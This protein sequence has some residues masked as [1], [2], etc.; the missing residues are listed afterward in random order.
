MLTINEPGH[1]HTFPFPFIQQEGGKAGPLR[2]VYPQ[3]TCHFRDLN[4]E[5][6][7]FFPMGTSLPTS[8][9]LQL[10]KNPYRPNIHLGKG[11]PLLAQV[12]EG[13]PETIDALLS[14]AES[15]ATPCS[16]KA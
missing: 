1:P 9:L 2:S 7:H 11:K 6:E 15:M 4:T 3:Q 16:V 13:C 5:I 10:R 8:Q 14:T 12:L